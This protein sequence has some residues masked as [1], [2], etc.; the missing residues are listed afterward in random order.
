MDV[1]GLVGCA[2]GFAWGFLFDA[3]WVGGSWTA[4]G[5]RPQVEEAALLRSGFGWEGKPVETGWEVDGVGSFTSPKRTGLAVR[6]VNGAE[7]GSPGW[8]RCWW[9][10][11]GA[12]GAGWW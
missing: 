12:C 6:P 1:G 11:G 7:K 4:K 3:R 8:F 10:F 9:T 5:G 2:L